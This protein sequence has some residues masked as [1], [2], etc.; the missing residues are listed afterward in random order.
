MKSWNEIRR[1]AMAFSKRWNGVNEG[2]VMI[3]ANCIETMK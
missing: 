3:I 1:A 2:S